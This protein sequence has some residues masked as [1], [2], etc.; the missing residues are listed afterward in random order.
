MVKSR[1]Y[2]NLAT[3][4]ATIRVALASLD[5]LSLYRR[6]TRQKSHALKS[7]FPNSTFFKGV[8][9]VYQYLHMLTYLYVC[10]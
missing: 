10:V 6:W 9:K 8:M 2:E 4:H 5:F 3:L 7:F 1:Q